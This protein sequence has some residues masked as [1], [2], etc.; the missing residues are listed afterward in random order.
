MLEDCVIGVFCWSGLEGCVRA[1]LEGCVVRVC[2]G[3]VLD[4]CVGGLC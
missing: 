4:G 2:F 3:G 1:C